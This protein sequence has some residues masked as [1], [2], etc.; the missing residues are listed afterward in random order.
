MFR[1]AK[2]NIVHVDPDIKNA[3]LIDFEIY[4]SYVPESDNASLG[5]LIVTAKGSSLQILRGKF[6][7]NFASIV[8][9]RGYNMIYDSVFRNN[10]NR[11]DGSMVCAHCRCMYNEHEL[12]PVKYRLSH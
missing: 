5:G 10:R 7:W 4:G 9:N 8:Y 11:R 12:H 3:K 1:N 6:G 2:D